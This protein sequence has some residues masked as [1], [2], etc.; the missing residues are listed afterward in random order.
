MRIDDAL[1]V[2]RVT[3]EPGG[4]EI[5]ISSNNPAYPSWDDVDRSEIQV[6]GRAI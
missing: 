5:K 3:L 1:V 6:V 4:R 2:K